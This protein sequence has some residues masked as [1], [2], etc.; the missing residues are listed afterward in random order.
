MSFNN[1]HQSI[2]Q[3]RLHLL[4]HMNSWH[5]GMS[6]RSWLVAHIIEALSDDEHAE[7]CSFGNMQGVL[8]DLAYYCRIFKIDEALDESCVDSRRIGREPET[9]RKA[10]YLPSPRLLLPIDAIDNGMIP[11]LSDLFVID[12]GYYMCRRNV[13][14]LYFLHQDSHC[15]KAMRSLGMLNDDYP[16]SNEQSA[17]PTA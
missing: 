10:K 5:Q 12:I 16:L 6:L 9:V 15:V 8:F 3:E 14:E 2:V 4:Q 17:S 13:V 1:D 11:P 7:N